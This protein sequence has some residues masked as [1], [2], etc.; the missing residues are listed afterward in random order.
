[1]SDETKKPQVWAEWISVNRKAGR[2]DP[3]P[4]GPDLKAGKIL[5]Q[6]VP[7]AARRVQILELYLADKDAFLVRTGHALRNL[8]A[9]INA[10]LNPNV[11]SRDSWTVEDWANDFAEEQWKQ[12]LREKRAAGPGA[13]IVAGRDGREYVERDENRW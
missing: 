11:K 6:A 3:V 9:R 8:Q 7:D 13:L 1:M 4:L 10:Y 5:G 2:A 12:A